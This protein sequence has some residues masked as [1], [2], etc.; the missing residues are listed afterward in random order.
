[1]EMLEI[2][3]NVRKFLEKSMEQWRLLLTSNGGKSWDV[4]VKRGI[5]QGDGLS[6]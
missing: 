1:M 6:P 3:E 4:A 2:T 5:F